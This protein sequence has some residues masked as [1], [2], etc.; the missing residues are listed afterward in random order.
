MKLIQAAIISILFVISSSV[1]AETFDIAEGPVSGTAR[2]NGKIYSFTEIDYDVIGSN[3]ARIVY[4]ANIEEGVCPFKIE[5]NSI[6]KNDEIQEIDM[7]NNVHPI[8]HSTDNPLIYT[9]K[10][11]MILTS[12]HVV[13]FDSKIRFDRQIT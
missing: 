2:I 8:I 1:Y 12:G 9:A 4:I 10:M 11:Q 13:F 5:L 7:F 3:G 6:L